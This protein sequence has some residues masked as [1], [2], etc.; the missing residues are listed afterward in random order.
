MGRFLTLSTALVFLLPTS[1]VFSQESGNSASAGDKPLDNT[2]ALIR[3]AKETYA[4]LEA[5]YRAGERNGMVQLEL[6]N[7]WSRRI[8]IAETQ[9]MAAMTN[10]ADALARFTNNMNSE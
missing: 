4:R 9:A 10:K 2:N 3:T 1:I 8:T 5:E 6:L 7:L